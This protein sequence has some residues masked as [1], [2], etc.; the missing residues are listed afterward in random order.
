MPER[1]PGPSIKDDE[2]YEKLR[3]E[4]NSKEKSARIANAAAAQGRSKIGEKGG[5]SGSYED[6]TVDELRSRAKELGLHNYSD[7]K[8]DDL[9]DKLREH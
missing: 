9:I 7:L 6:W 1:D 2:L 8:K 3:D 4:G 5:E